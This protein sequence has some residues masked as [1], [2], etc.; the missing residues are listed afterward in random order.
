MLL[1]FV[2][3]PRDL[4]AFVDAHAFQQQIVD[5]R[6]A[7]A[8]HRDGQRYQ[9]GRAHAFGHQ[10]VNVLPGGDILSVIIPSSLPVSE[11]RRS[12]APTVAGSCADAFPKRPQWRDN[13][14]C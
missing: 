3:E 14:C 11:N 2:F 13:K 7:F 9:A 12:N 8:R 6:F 4:G 1:L 5:R 10:H